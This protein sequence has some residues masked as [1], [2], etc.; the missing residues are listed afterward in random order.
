MNQS[1]ANQTIMNKTFSE[2]SAAIADNMMKFDP[3]VEKDAPMKITKKVYVEYKK[4]FQ[5]KAKSLT[6][7]DPQH[8]YSLLKHSAGKQFMKQ[9]DTLD[10]TEAASREVDPVKEIFEIM[11]K[12]FDDNTDD[13][14]ARILFHEIRQKTTEKHCDFFDRIVTE[15]KKCGYNKDEIAREVISMVRAR[16]LDKDLRRHAGSAESTIVSIRRLATTID[17]DDQMMAHDEKPAKAAKVNRVSS[18]GSGKLKRKRESSSSSLETNS[19]S[20]DEAGQYLVKKEQKAN[21][22]AKNRNGD[23]PKYQSEETRRYDPVRRTYRDHYEQPPRSR[24]FGA[25]RYTKC[26]RCLGTNHESFR[27]YHKE[28]VCLRCNV[29]GHLQ[30]ACNAPERSRG[31]QHRHRESEKKPKREKRSRDTS[32]AKDDKKKAN[33]HNVSKVTEHE[34]KKPSKHESSDS[35]AFSSPE[36]RPKESN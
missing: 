8:L 35:P 24:N 5:H 16:A 29:R 32:V 28:S 18:K 19:D 9:L 10:L 3:C 13:V 17:M 1:I 33:V 22:F 34:M 25:S 14:N 20:D 26:E 7:Q 4:Y 23:R 21:K 12:F 2:M 30:R 15:S 11:D 31:H 36:Y 27:C 6:N